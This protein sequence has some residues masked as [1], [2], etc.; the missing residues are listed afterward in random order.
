M[1]TWVNAPADSEESWSL[2]PAITE[3][4][5]SKAPMPSWQ[6]PAAPATPAVET[7]RAEL[8]G[9]ETVQERVE[10]LVKT[11][12]KSAPSA[13]EPT[14]RNRANACRRAKPAVGARACGGRC[15]LRGGR[16][17]HRQKHRRCS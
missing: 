12:Q 11:V 14:S 1:P 7:G 15:T 3:P 6:V 9:S 16:N 2:P 5:V 13:S 17:G 8:A 4:A 10:P